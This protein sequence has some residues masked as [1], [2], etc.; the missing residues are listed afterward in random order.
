MNKKERQ[1]LIREQK[2]QAAARR[3][4][5]RRMAT[6]LAMVVLVPL[7]VIGVLY[8]LLAQ[9]EAP[10]PD[11]VTET[12]HVRGNP[13]G[14]TLVVYADFQC[15]A[16][17]TEHRVINQAWPEI[18]N[19]VQ[20]VYRH[21][22]LTDSH[23][24]AFTAAAYAEAAGQQGRFWEMHDLLFNNQQSW[25]GMSR[26]QA[27]ETFDGYLEEL[28]LDLEQAHQDME[29]EAVLQKIRNDQRGAVRAGVRGTP[30]LFLEGDRQS[31][32]RTA[33]DLIGMIDEAAQ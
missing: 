20:Q 11:E 5:F 33:G 16:C 10:G 12:D 17:A 27:R 29:S 1:R 6:R 18:R 25:S 21:F 15:P 2:R 7:V 4:R 9:G 8:G 32:P 26:Q 14:L 13:D 19:R 3:A 28:G 30:T 23:P 24:H 31:T 22:P